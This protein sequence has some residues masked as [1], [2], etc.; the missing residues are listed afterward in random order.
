[1]AV[2]ANQFPRNE[3]SRERQGR[4][5][6]LKP[7]SVILPAAKNYFAAGIEPDAFRPLHVEVTKK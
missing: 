3:E 5:P 1:M 4:L 7:A 2:P 6:A